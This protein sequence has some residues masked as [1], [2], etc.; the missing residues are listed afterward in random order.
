METTPHMFVIAKDGTLAYEGAIDNHPAPNGDP[1]TAKNYVSAA[2]DELLAGK[3]VTVAETKPYGC[4]V[5]Y[6]D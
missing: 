5:K 1:R 2:V 4:S 6:A 3:P